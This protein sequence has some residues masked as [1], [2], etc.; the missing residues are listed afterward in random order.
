MNT[1][2]T[3]NKT[4][5][6]YQLI[7][8]DRYDIANSTVVVVTDKFIKDFVKMQKSETEGVV[9]SLKGGYKGLDNEEQSFLWVKT[10]KQLNADS[11]EFMSEFD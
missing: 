6:N 2:N 8:I 9:A 7:V 5:Q 3:Q 11:E 1:T 10:D 4:E